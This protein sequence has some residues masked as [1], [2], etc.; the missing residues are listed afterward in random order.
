MTIEN[1]IKK[2]E[3]ET[4]KEVNKILHEAGVKVQELQAEANKEL[5]DELN[6]IRDE[7]NKRIT[8]MRNIHLSEA[9]RVSRREI[10]SAKENL[11]DECFRQAKDRLKSL[12]G[13]EYNNVLRGLINESLPLIGEKGKV[14]LTRAEDKALLSSFPNLTVNPNLASGLGGILL[15]SYDGKIVVNNTFDAILERRKEDIR[16]EIANI[17]FTG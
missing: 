8:I 9:R 11:I 2:I 16:T 7:G 13:E 1:I 5:T 12:S 17:L 15:E 14:T 4:A 3:M 10:L 6:K